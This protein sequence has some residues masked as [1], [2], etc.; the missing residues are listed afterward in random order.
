[1]EQTARE[2][3]ESSFLQIEHVDV[4][5]GDK[6]SGRLGSPGL[7]VGLEYLRSL[8]QPKCF[9]ISMKSKIFILKTILLQNWAREGTVKRSEE[10]LNFFPNLP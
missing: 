8:F 7:M 3:V 10:A 1:M 2:V 4:A 5:H 9:Y 6:F